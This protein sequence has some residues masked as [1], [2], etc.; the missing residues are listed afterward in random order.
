[1]FDDEED[2][3]SS[4]ELN[5]LKEAVLRAQQRREEA[6]GIREAL[7]AEA[8]EVAQLAVNAEASL[9]KVRKQLEDVTAELHAAELDAAQLQDAVA[10]VQAQIAE[11]AATASPP[12]AE[13]GDAVEASL[14]FTSGATGTTE[15][16]AIEEADAEAPAGQTLEDLLWQRTQE[17]NE[18]AAHIAELHAKIAALNTKLCAAE[19]AY[20]RADA[21]A[22]AAMETAEEAVRNEMDCITV[23]NETESALM[24]AIE[25]LRFL[26]DSSERREEE[27]DKK[28]K[29]G[30]AATVA[31]VASVASVVSVSS[32]ASVDDVKLDAASLAAIPTKAAGPAVSLSE[33]E[34]ARWASGIDADETPGT[35]KQKTFVP[36]ALTILQQHKYAIVG[37]AVALAVG[38]VALQQS[39]ALAVLAAKAQAAVAAAS[40]LWAVALELAS[41]LPLPHIHESEKGILETIWLLLASVITVPLIIKIPGGSAVLGFLAGGALIGPYALGIIQDV[42]SI[43]HLAELGVVFLLFN[44][45]LELSFDRLRSMQKFVFGMGSAQVAITLAA[46]AF[47]SLA[48]LGGSLGGPGAVILGGG[49]AL[50]TTAVGMQVLQDR[51]ESGSRHGR[52]AFSVLLLQDLAVVVL[53]MLI[54][55]LAPSPDGATGKIPHQYSSLIY[56]ILSLNFKSEFNLVVCMILLE[57]M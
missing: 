13:L 39:G 24:K 17:A 44:I 48:F 41:R 6:T 29:A 42:E 56:R 37:C 43:R 26:D 49:L 5:P 11:G 34:K 38:G 14:D 50:S 20:Q 45:G 3:E 46:V 57:F 2:V 35:K 30:A 51:G 52:A 31:S 10:A 22:A 12:S 7:E 8:Q 55:L 23:A 36:R 28:A 53:L 54:P 1:M 18:A 9:L 15:G 40:R 27:F 16:T 21:I 47:V 25:D 33:V 4:P 32:L 19:E